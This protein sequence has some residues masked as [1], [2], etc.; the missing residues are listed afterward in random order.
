MTTVKSGLQMLPHIH[1]GPHINNNYLHECHR[2]SQM[3]G[4][5]F[6]T[7]GLSCKNGFDWH[8][9]TCNTIFLFS[10]VIWLTQ[11]N[12]YCMNMDVI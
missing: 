7:L 4:I 5:Y 6:L 8:G 12:K 2:V 1:P 9:Y 11:L 3:F 10:L